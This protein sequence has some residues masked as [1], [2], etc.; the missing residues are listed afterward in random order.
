MNLEI[1]S[2]LVED[3]KEAKPVIEL[4]VFKE[5]RIPLD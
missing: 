2:M 1:L 3:A 5:L 4:H